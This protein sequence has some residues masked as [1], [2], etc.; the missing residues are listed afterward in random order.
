MSFE[1]A[2]NDCVNR[3]RFLF[4][5]TGAVAAAGCESVNT[6]PQARV[7]DAG[8]ASHFA[9]DGVY[10]DFR[11]AG[12]FIIRKNGKLTVLS[13]ICTHRRFKLEAEAGRTF[14]CARHGSRFDADGVVT[15]GPAT[16]ALPAFSTSTDEN[17][18][19]LVHVIG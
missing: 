19:L 11:D 3:R 7:V 1:C 9:A 18:H 13:S 17:G 16:R 8:P 12:F 10:A 15:E 5:T 2:K 6:A 14:Y 4:L